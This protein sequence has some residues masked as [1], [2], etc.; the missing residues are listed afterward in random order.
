MRAHIVHLLLGHHAR[1]GERERHVAE[2]F[3]D[4]KI[5][6]ALV[7]KFLAVERL[8]VDGGKVGAAVI[9]EK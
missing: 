4:G 5:A 2:I 8:E 7:A 6:A 9:S 1:K 3:G